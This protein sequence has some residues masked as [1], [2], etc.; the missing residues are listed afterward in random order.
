MYTSCAANV[1]C[2]LLLCRS[3]TAD[4][5]SFKREARSPELPDDQGLEESCNNVK[6][7]YEMSINPQWS[8][9]NRPYT[10][11]DE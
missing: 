1:G 4:T 7:G 2:I 8:M 5:N 11:S 6:H 3:R 10:G 9:S